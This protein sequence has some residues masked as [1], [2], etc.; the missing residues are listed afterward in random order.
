M[1][2]NTKIDDHALRASGIDELQQVGVLPWRI[3]RDGAPKVLLITSRRRGRWIVPKG[4]PMKGY[5][6]L[7]AAA[8]EAFEEAGIIGDMWPSPVTTY[9]YMKALDDGSEI[10]CRVAVFGMNVRG[11]L[12][13]WREKDQRQ[14]RWFS[15]E[16]AADRLDD[17]E[18]SAFV[19]ALATAPERLEPSDRPASRHLARAGPSKIRS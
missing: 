14:R 3:R 19:R 11:T 18:L 6:L 2:H 16:A 1:S 10:P 13:H 4:W 12:T 9:R 8:R 5:P 17:I 15:V 7:V